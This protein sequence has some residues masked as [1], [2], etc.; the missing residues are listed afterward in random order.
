MHDEPAALDKE[1]ANLAE[2]LNLDRNVTPAVTPTPAV[3]LVTLSKVLIWLVPQ[4][5]LEPPT[6]SL[7]M[8]PIGVSLANDKSRSIPKKRQS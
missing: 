6:P 3:P 5:G 2:P 1:A 7:R 8:T 4:E